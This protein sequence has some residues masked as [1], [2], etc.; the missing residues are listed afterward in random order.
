MVYNL[1]HCCPIVSNAIPLGG[2]IVT[3]TGAS[4]NDQR[5]L[6]G[7][8]VADIIHFRLSGYEQFT[9]GTSFARRLVGRCHL[10]TFTVTAFFTHGLRRTWWGH[11]DL[12]GISASFFSIDT[13]DLSNEGKRITFKFNGCILT[14]RITIN[15]YIIH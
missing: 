13:W 3:G 8:G 10:G 14:C 11:T 1:L 7:L 5:D 6:L 2:F 4:Q 12:T 9:N 15:N